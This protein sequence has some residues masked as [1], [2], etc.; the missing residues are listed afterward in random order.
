MEDLLKELLKVRTIIN[1]TIAEVQMLLTGGKLVV[2]FVE[3]V[4]QDSVND[5]LSYDPVCKQFYTPRRTE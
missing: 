2:H 5:A 4:L 3:R 1:D